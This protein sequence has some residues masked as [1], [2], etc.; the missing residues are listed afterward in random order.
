MV[1]ILP[2][3]LAAL[4]SAAA[5]A[6]KAVGATAAGLG[7]KAAAVG[8][9]A[10]SAAGKAALGTTGGV[11]P[12]SS[13]GLGG[14]LGALGQGVKAGGSAVLQS[15]KSNP[16]MGAAGI[17]GRTKKRTAE[18]VELAPLEGQAVDIGADVTARLIAERERRRR[19]FFAMLGLN[20][21]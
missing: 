17:L 19:Q 20:I 18:P 1:L 6:A 3:F 2:A 21:P 10:A 15:A 4:G 11:V 13:I 14:T 12:S 8:P 9:A 16:L 7:A 5:G